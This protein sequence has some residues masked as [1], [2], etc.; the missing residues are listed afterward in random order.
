MNA[1]SSPSA[2]PPPIAAL[3]RPGPLA[4]PLKYVKILRIS[5]MERLVYRADFFVATLFRFLPLLTI[6]Y[7]FNYLDRYVVSAVLTPIAF[8][9]SSTSD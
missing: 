3:R 2:S 9:F 4:G 1:T 7:L 5:L 8:A 6:A